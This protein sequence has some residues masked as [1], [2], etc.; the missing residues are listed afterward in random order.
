[1][2]APA[3]PQKLTAMGNEEMLSIPIES[4]MSK[5]KT[6]QSG[7]SSREASR[8][9]GIY[10][11]NELAKK[12]KRS[13]I[14]EFLLHFK[15]PLIIIL[16][17]A[18]TVSSLL[19]DLTDSAIIYIIILFSVMLD[20]VQEH[21]AGKAAEKLREKIVTTATVVRDGAKQEVPIS[22]IVPGD[23]IDLSSGDIVPA[24]ARLVGAKDFF[25]DQSALTGESFPVEKAP[26]N[27]E[28]EDLADS[29]K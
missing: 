6:S 27:L 11:H 19:G 24:D 4:L 25:V 2:G 14:V 18:G 26:N 28:L 1:M 22:K 21:K 29:A 3:A 5:L 20:S 7:L 13:A 16:L 12:P 9:L 23:I 15:N 8:L 17:A 10:G